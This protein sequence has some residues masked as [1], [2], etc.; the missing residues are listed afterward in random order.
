MERKVIYFEK[1]GK[2][3]S[4]DCLR[5]VKD[6]IK[7][8][9][10][11]HIVIATT[12]GETGLLFA[13]E[14]KDS[15]LNI[16][17]VTHS[18]GFKAPNTIE[19]TGET[20]KKIESFGARVYTGS[21]LTHSIETAFTSRFQGL[22]P[23]MIVAQSLRR[24]GEGSKVC[25]EIVMMAADAGLIPEEEEVIAVAGTARGADSVLVVRSAASKR[26]LDLKVLEV[27][28]KPRG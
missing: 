12:E 10:Y 15:G 4:P 7:E 22:H 27:L 11:R 23:T 8:G 28:A 21:M 25:C 1:P 19:M 16:I 26:F 3:N 2:E 13:E 5:I 24:F 6:A 14:L 17:A 20:R 18:S 9:G